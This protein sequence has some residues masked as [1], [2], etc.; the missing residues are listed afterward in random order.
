MPWCQCGNPLAYGDRRCSKLTVVAYPIFL[1]ILLLSFYVKFMW[2]P[3]VILSA[4]FICTSCSHCSARP[5]RHANS[6]AVQS[7]V[8]MPAAV[9][10]THPGGCG[11][12]Q[13][14][15]FA[16][17]R[18]VGEMTCSVCLEALQDGEMVR[19][20]PACLH[21]F[22]VACIDMWLGSHSTCPL[23][24]SSVQVAKT[25]MSQASAPATADPTELPV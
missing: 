20:L 5:L 3:L 10:A 6:T 11:A 21:Q 7:E 12:H 13:I 24:R 15:S 19:Q 17:E 9:A 22:H 1:V 16:F 4:L 18:T 25:D 14:P 2:V 23:C 8:S